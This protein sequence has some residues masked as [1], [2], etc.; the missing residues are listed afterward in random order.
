[1]VQ[2]TVRRYSALPGLPSVRATTTA[3]ARLHHQTRNPPYHQPLNLSVD[4]LSV[5]V[6]LTPCSLSQF[7]PLTSRIASSSSVVHRRLLAKPQPN[8]SRRPG[9]IAQSFRAS[10]LPQL[11]GEQTQTGQPIHR[12]PPSPD[13]LPS[14][15]VRRRLAPRSTCCKLFVSTSATTICSN[16]SSMTLQAAA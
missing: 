12:P 4:L 10:N 11:I 9:Q 14:A 8:S 7:R 15:S 5:S 2:P 13:D 3:F 6:H 1:M 16:Y